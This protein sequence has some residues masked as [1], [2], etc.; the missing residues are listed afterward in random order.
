MSGNTTLSLTEFDDCNKKPS[1]DCSFSEKCCCFHEMS[2]D[3]DFE[4]NLKV[5]PFKVFSNPIIVET[6]TT[7]N[8]VFDRNSIP[9]SYTNLPPPGG[10]ELLK[11]VQVYRL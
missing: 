8:T 11:R 1:N 7:L 2:F 4:T 6:T 5:K 3:F 9:F 10:I